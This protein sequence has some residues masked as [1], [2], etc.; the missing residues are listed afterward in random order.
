MSNFFFR[1]ILI[2][3]DNFPLFSFTF[4][5]TC[6]ISR[7]YRIRN[8]LSYIY[9]TYLTRELILLRNV[10]C[11]F[12]RNAASTL[13]TKSSVLPYCGS[14]KYHVCIN[15]NICIISRQVLFCAVIGLALVMMCLKGFSGPWYRYMFRFVLLFSYIIPISL[16]VNLDMGKAF[17]AWC[18]Q[19]DKDIVGTVVRTTTIP[20][21]LGRISYLLSDKTGTLTQNKMVFKKLHLGT[22]S[23]GQ[24]TFDEVTTVLKSYYSINSDSSPVKAAPNAHSG[25]VRRSENTRIYDAVHALALCHNVTPVYDDVTRTTNLDTVSVQT[26]ETGDTG[27]IQRYERFL[28]C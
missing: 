24:E 22:I 4:F 20:E 18:I 26:G 7:V 16:R 14:F 19:R 11:K 6:Y 9:S 27:S 23:Y 21:E 3:S 1:Q 15:I 13:E 2:D 8:I 10:E 17:Y 25:K 5:K 12:K 28:A